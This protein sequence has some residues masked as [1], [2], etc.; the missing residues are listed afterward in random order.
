[1]TPG[2]GTPGWSERGAD[3]PLFFFEATILA[4]STPELTLWQRAEHHAAQGR[5]DE[6]NK[7]YEALARHP[8]WMVV[9]HLQLSHVALEQ[10]RLRDSVS[11]ALKAA[12]G[13]QDEGALAAAVVKQCFDVGEIKAGLEVAQTAVLQASQEPEVLLEVAQSLCDQS[14]P[15]RTLPLLERVAGMGTL[16]AKLFYLLGIG[17]MFAGDLPAA[18]ASFERCL[19]LQPDNA[20][21]HYMLAG[22]K[23]QTGTSHHV[24]RLRQAL[25]RL[26]SGHPNA[27]LLQY[28]L[29]KELDDLGD[30]AAAWPALAAGMHGRRAQ[31]R[32]DATQ[33]QILFEALH[34]V[35]PSTEDARQQET[36]PCPI[37][38]VGLPRSGTTLLE[39]MLGGHSQVTDAGELR[40]FTFRAR[41]LTDCVGSP[42]TD[43][44]LANAMSRWADW[45]ELGSEYLSHTQWRAAGRPFYTDKLPVNY[46]NVG[47]IAKSLPTAR[48]VHMVRDPMDVCFSNL[49]QLFAPGNAHSFDQLEMADHWVR[50]RGLM[51]H[52]HRAFPG[53]VLD[54]DYGELVTQPE[55]A[56]RRVLEFCGL[57]WEPDVVSIE[58]REGAVAT[59]SM[60]QVRE[61]VHTRFLGQWQRY[62]EQLEPMRQRLAAAGW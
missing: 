48:I 19:A 1:M 13:E 42:E 33:E 10:G 15:D 35:L 22:A 14:F 57:P 8:D 60:V 52:W 46:L 56:A 27:P 40:D 34:R 37:F 32:Y 51:Q 47:W 61:A 6:A 11:A 28:A 9:A 20:A 24:P 17:R 18:E 39:R 59:A 25:G 62:A 7:A 23:R 3:R 45:H 12:T 16:N 43:N 44:A 50:Y 29:F 4:M 55:V 2:R 30:V 54:V 53:R 38:V 26:A 41:C 21:A 31:V 36:G 58:A 5:L 49:K